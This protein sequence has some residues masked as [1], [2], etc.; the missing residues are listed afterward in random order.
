MGC[1]SISVLINDR[2]NP[3]YMD[4]VDGFY[5][6]IAASDLTLNKELIYEGRL[7]KENIYNYLDALF[8]N[9]KLPDGIISPNN[10]TSKHILSW[11]KE[12]NLKIPKD[13]LFVGFSND[14]NIPNADVSL[15]TVQFSGS[16]IGGKA[17]KAL[18][19][20]IEKSKILNETILI[21]AKFIIKSS[22]LKV[23][24]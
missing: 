20:Q 1:Q 2:K 12:K 21:P 7:V 23:M 13:L 9:S 11:L 17:A 3:Y 24:K 22:S 18:I 16:E 10:I 6:A 5:S 8:E 14:K 15:T 19:D 4:I